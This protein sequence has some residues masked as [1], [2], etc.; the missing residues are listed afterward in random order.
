M[1]G[2]RS[3]ESHDPSP[4]IPKLRQC[5]LVE[6]PEMSEGRWLREYH[7]PAA[8]MASE[9]FR[10]QHLPAVAPMPEEHRLANEHGVVPSWGAWHWSR[11]GFASSRVK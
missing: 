7:P 8:W 11:M 6:P 3:R 9:P 1:A 5:P 4:R 2:D 10:F